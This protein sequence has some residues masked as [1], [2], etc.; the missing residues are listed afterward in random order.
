MTKFISPLQNP[1]AP[2]WLVGDKKIYNQFEAAKIAFVDG[3][4]AYRFVFLDEQY[5]RLDWSK[6]PKETWD[7]LCTAQAHLI[8]NKYKKIKLLF[9]AG[10]DSGHIWR[11]FEK[12]EIPIDELTLIYSPYHPLRRYE[13]EN[14]ILPMAK[15]LCKKHPHMTVRVLEAGQAQYDRQFGNSDW[16]E[17]PHAR[18]G[19]MVFVPYHYSQVLADLD[20]DSGDPAVGYVIGMEKPRLRL[21]DGNFV[22]RHLDVDVNHMVFNFPNLEWFYWAPE[23]P[24]LFLKQCWMLINHLETYYPGASS[25]FVEHFQDTHGP[26]YDEFSMCV[27]RGTAMIWACGNGVQKT[28]DNY[29]WSVQASIAHAKNNQW[30]SYKEWQL[31]MDDLQKNWAHCFNQNDPYKGSIGIWGKPYCIK[32]QNLDTIV[33]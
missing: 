4:P 13:H 10:R 17:G 8:R 11:V 18:Q 32:K 23:M 28:K 2:Y 6:E 1:Y 20:P 7:Q 5:D 25:E 29:H 22:F 3:G 27:G 15:Q 16:L 31:I 24:E 33:A 30:Q 21:V 12:A 14:Y 26:Y 9:S 19:R